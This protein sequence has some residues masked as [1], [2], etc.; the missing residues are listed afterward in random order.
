MTTEAIETEGSGEQQMEQTPWWGKAQNLVW[1]LGPVTVAFMGLLAVILGWLPSPML[2]G[3]QSGTTIL[4]QNQKIMT[5]IRTD[6]TRH[7][8]RTDQQQGDQLKALRQICRNTANSP[9][10]N[11]RC[12]EIQQ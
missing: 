6:I 10:Q 2:E 12:D 3:L 8:E 1:T 9:A 7:V 11:E 4:Q 5:E